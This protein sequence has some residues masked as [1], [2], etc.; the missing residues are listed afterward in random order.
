MQIGDYKISSIKTG[1]FRLDGGSMFGVVPKTIWNKSNPSD[2]KNRIEMSTNVLLLES[3]DRKIL[4]DTGIGHKMSDKLNKI[5][6]VDYSEYTL[7]K[8]LNNLSIK[9]ED[10][11]DVILTHLHFDHAGGSTIFDE[12]NTPLPAFKNAVYHVQ[13]KHLDWALNPTERDKASFF[14]EN[15]EPMIKSKQLK[16]VDEKHKFDDFITLIPLNGHTRSMQIVKISDGK[17][18]LVYLAD[19]I[20]MSAHV[21]LP[22]IMG[23]DLFPLVTLEEKREYLKEIYEN[24][25][26]V[27]F[28]HDP[29]VEAGKIGFENKSYFLKEKL[30]V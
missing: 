13:E 26:T 19:L 2:D 23:Y 9:P 7:E 27:F 6:G 22:Y 28:E 1:L 16:T 24:N 14:P 29:Y 3:K 8:G 4:V 11:T 10:I 12:R 5:Y 30:N 17:E 21:P 25:Y 15:Y 20:P 18:A